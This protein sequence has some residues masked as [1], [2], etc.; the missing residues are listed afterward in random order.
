MANEE[1]RERQNK[2]QDALTSFFGDENANGTSI[3]KELREL[4]IEQIGV[5]ATNQL[6]YGA[7]TK[8]Q[9]VNQ[10]AI[11]RL[12][13]QETAVELVKSK[14]T[15][16]SAFDSYQASVSG[17]YESFVQHCKDAGVADCSNTASA[18]EGVIRTINPSLSEAELVA[19][20]EEQ[21][22]SIEENGF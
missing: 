12:T 15:S 20:V 19:S 9:D 5:E 3:N 14:Y 8:G 7:L 10:V 11:A 17:D 21:L 4:L 16:D 1:A 2:L 13:N 6:I 18:L 22:R